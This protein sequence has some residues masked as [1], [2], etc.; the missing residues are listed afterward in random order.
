MMTHLA[1]TLARWDATES[2][3]KMPRGSVA[4]VL[5]WPGATSVGLS[6]STADA[7]ATCREEF[8]RGAERG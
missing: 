8:G 1:A 7:C 5:E 4:S 2:S 3:C 6:A